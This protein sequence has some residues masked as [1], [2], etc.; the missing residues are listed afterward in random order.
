M[1]ET[2]DKDLAFLG[3]QLLEKA[4]EAPLQERM[5]RFAVEH[6][7]ERSIR[8]LRKAVQEGPDLSDVVSADRDERL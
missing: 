6:G 2:T 1:S 7:S 8:E 4:G 3:R 5:R